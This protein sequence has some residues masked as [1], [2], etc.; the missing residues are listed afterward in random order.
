MD[1]LFRAPPG[2]EL[3]AHPA[4][5][6]HPEMCRRPCVHMFRHGRCHQGS[7]CDYCHERHVVPP[8]KMTKRLRQLF[9]K[10]PRQQQMFILLCHLT[11]RSAQSDFPA[12]ANVLLQCLVSDWQL[13]Q[14][15]QQSDHAE[16][17]QLGLTSEE[18]SSMQQA[19]SRMPLFALVTQ[20]PHSSPEH[21]RD[22]IQQVQWKMAFPASS[23]NATSHVV[24]R[25]SL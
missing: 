1:R 2:L 25:I 23:R 21:V 20:F 17:V 15:G 6:G 5:F 11:E 4:S 12:E 16:H 10:L 22:L 18:L 19:F 7:Q 14:R 8:A 24:Y 9:A 13:M 3:Q